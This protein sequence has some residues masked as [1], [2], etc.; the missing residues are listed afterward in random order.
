[1]TF[2]NI[3]LVL[4]LLFNLYLLTPPFLVVLVFIIV[5]LNPPDT[6]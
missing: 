4:K 6:G 2:Y 3:K 5:G 1:M